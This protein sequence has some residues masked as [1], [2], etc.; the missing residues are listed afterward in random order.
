[1]PPSGAAVFEVFSVARARI[2]AV[3]IGA[4]DLDGGARFAVQMAVA[5]AVL[6][7]VA[8]DAVHALVQ[9]DVAQVDGLIE[10]LADR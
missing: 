5:V 10:L 1:M 4:I 3:A 2:G 9:M 8:I 6:L 7:E